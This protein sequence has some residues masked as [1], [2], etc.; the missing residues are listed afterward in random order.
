VAEKV[1]P[2]RRGPTAAERL[3][4]K[5]RQLRAV[6]EISAALASAW[7][8]EA[9]LDV[10]TRITSEVMA[11]ASCSIYLSEKATDRLVLKA[12]TGLAKSAIG[13]ASLRCGEGL[14][15]WTVAHGRAVAA[16]DARLDPRFKLL[17][18][19]S[20]ES[21]S[22]LLAVPLIVQGR[23]IGAMNVQTAEPH[24]YSDEEIELLSLIANLAAGAIEKATLYDHMRQQIG[25][26]EALAAVSRA[27]IS[28]LYL[29]EMLAVVAEMAARVMGAKA[30]VLHLLDE[31]SG[32]LALRAAH[33]VSAAHRS[34]P[35][36]TVGEGIVGQVAKD[37]TPIV[38]TDVR[39]DSRYRN[40]ALAEAE[41]LVSLLSVPLIVRERTVGVLSCYTAVP[42]EFSP[43]EI[44]V[45]SMLANQ[46]ALAIE[47]ARLVIGSVVV[48]EMHHRI[49]NNLQT[50]AMLL[51]L[52][53]GA[54]EEG[55]AKDV[56]GDAITRVLSIA[57]VHETLSEQGLEL[58]DVRQVL[59]R[60]AQN[61]AGLAPTRTITIEVEGDAL[62][63]PSRAATSLALTV[64]ELVQNA[65][66]H[67]FVQRDRGRITISL[68]AG[69]E[70]CEVV[71]ADDGIGD[72][73]E[74]RARRGLGFD[75]VHTLVTH[76]LKGRVTIGSTSDGTRAVVRFPT[77]AA[78]GVD[79]GAT[80]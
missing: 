24:G 56:L 18:E 13:R 49:K 33:N 34:G 43:K 61:V 79:E 58:V 16:T 29:D 68:N 41:G 10:I 19:T 57:A 75:I 51:R 14:T 80:P 70:E 66:K 20:E 37:A 50:V 40:R 60:V 73:A 1:A 25:E 64:T 23:T 31:A 72:G 52:E 63:L 2:A 38:V 5:T 7:E 65:V 62:S 12:T 45:F 47:N 22:S 15:G 27:I 4:L 42:H 28:P 17:P 59:E 39:N 67:A 53:M 35:P 54:A 26:L 55:R 6:G 36:L 3:A 48:R 71:V 11:V 69:R 8:L 77:A 32:R 44:D 76:D 78:P 9:T 74:R 46:T 30:V 21:L